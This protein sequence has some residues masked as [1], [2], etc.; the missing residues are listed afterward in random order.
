MLRSG[1]LTEE[2]LLKIELRRRGSAPADTSEFTNLGLAKKLGVA[3]ST[4]KKI[5]KKRRARLAAN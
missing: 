1:R 3:P 5:L 4:L 2:K